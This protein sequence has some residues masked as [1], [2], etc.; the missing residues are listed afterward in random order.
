MDKQFDWISV[1]SGASGLASALWAAH[2]GLK[3]IVLEKA[4]VVGGATAYSYGGLWAPNNMLQRNAGVEDSDEQGLDYLRYLSGG[5]AEEEKMRMY[6]KEAAATIDTFTQLGISFRIIEGLPDHY[7]PGAPGSLRAGRTLEVVPLAKKA[8]PDSAP[9]LLESPYMP[10]GVSWT[11]AIEWGGLGNRYSWPAE[12]LAYA[13]SVYAAGQGLV[14][15]LLLKCMEKGVTIST[16][17]AA[18]RLV[19]EDGKVA[20]VEVDRGQSLRSNRGVFLGTGGYESNPEFVRAYQSFP[21]SAPHHPP[22]QT[23]DGLLMAGEIGAFI[24]NIPTSLSSMVGY[25]I[26]RQDGEPEFHS[27]GI[28]ELAYPHAIVVN[29]EGK[30]F[31][32]EAFF[33]EFV[34]KLRE[35]DVV[36]KHRYANLPFF[37]L[38]DAQ[39]RERYP[40]ANIAPGR[41]LPS[42]VQRADSLGDLARQLGIDPTQLEQTVTRF[43]DN[44]SAGLDPD[45]GRGQS[46][47]IRKV[48]DAKHPINPNLG[49]LSKAPFYG[50]ELTPTESSSAGLHTDVHGR[51]MHLRGHA[52]PNLYAGGTVRVRT[53]Y[54]AGYQAGLTLLGG[55]TFGRVAVE[56]ALS[57][58]QKPN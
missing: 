44:A 23:G 20:G 39:F 11:D 31:G 28:Q 18:S 27:A 48:G 5:F 8:L 2:R 56:H 26:P 58:D 53:E 57:G 10:G 4:A 46:L 55:M 50:V 54:G 34:V 33:Q 35:F 40:F 12:S 17:S 24:R 13:A 43:N 7:F 47:W 9:A 32:N 41:P 36:K 45:F 49:P 42:W 52:I 51:V 37:L 19:L 14:A 30:R 1:G 38:F 25:W 22:T 16:Q 6:V 21:N 29:S 3:T 15:W